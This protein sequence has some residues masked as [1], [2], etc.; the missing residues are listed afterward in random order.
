MR[1]PF[2]LKRTSRLVACFAMVGVQAARKTLRPKAKPGSSQPFFSN[3]SKSKIPSRPIAAFRRNE[4]VLQP[5]PEETKTTPPE[6]KQKMEKELARYSQPMPKKSTEKNVNK[7]LSS[8]I[9]SLSGTRLQLLQAIGSLKEDSKDKVE[10]IFSLQNEVLT[11]SRDKLSTL[12]TQ[13]AGEAAQSMESMAEKF[14]S[15]L[16]ISPSQAT[17]Y[18]LSCG[19]TTNRS[20]FMPYARKL[21]DK[22]KIGPL[23]FKCPHNCFYILN[24]KEL[25]TLLGPQFDFFT[26]YYNVT[27]SSKN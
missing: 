18:T 9:L 20:S 21:L 16:S 19:H 24:D 22:M 2:C 27:L 15:L 17:G 8:V 5:I 11:I 6:E 4:T 3:K 23:Q 13:F 26:R 1:F 7:T 10:E 25:V 12:D 14:Q